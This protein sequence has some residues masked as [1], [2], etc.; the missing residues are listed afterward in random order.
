MMKARRPPPK[1][2]R[3]IGQVIS[4]IEKLMA[5]RENSSCCVGVEALLEID[6]R[7]LRIG[8]GKRRR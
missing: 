1:G 5:M 8:T 6:A 2:R 4:P 7:R 3:D